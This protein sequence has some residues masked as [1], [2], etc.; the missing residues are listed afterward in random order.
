MKKH[1]Y[2]S[3]SE[4]YASVKNVVNHPEFDN[5]LLR[6]R[7]DFTGLSLSEILKSKYSYQPGV[8]II[9]NMAAVK[10]EKDEK[11]KYYDQF[12]GFDI[13]ID[14]MLDNLDFLINE[15]RVKKRPKTMNIYINI[16]EAGHVDY[17]R[18]INK[19]YAALRITDHL[20]TLGVRTAVFV[21]MPVTPYYGPRNK[22]HPETFYIEVCVKN[23]QDNVNLGALCTAIS[24]WFF[25]HWVFAW[26][27]GH[28]K[29]IDIFG[30]GIVTRMPD[31]EARNGILIN[32][33]DCHS[34]DTAN[35]FIENLKVA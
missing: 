18:M 27:I 11:I 30:V 6:D 34:I 5:H 2:N 9:N 35:N 21:S 25:R 31:D 1:Y 20:E 29:D 26:I 22:R 8:D 28:D 3:M 32:T 12:D 15:K 17:Q 4:F 23:Y 13:D 19:T 16:T 14:R 10:V 33:G 24:P 7:P